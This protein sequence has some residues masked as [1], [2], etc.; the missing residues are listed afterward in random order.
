MKD[1]KSKKFSTEVK[2]KLGGAEGGYAITVDLLKD[3]SIELP[4]PKAIPASNG[5][6]W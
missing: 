5:T 4:L 1:P 3:A 6:R 2:E